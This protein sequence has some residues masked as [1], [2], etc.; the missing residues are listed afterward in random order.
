MKMSPEIPENNKLSYRSLNK[1]KY[2]LTDNYF[3]YLKRIRGFTINYEFFQIDINGTAVIKKNYAW[4]G[5]SGPTID[6][7]TFMRGSLIHDMLYQAIRLRFLPN[8]YRKEADETL[9]D[10][11][12]EDG[13]NSF[14]AFYVYNAVRMFGWM[15]I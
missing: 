2:Q 6:T 12:L 4:D 7:K 5:P 15:A 8:A 1:Y 14:R 9:R 10:I 3:C 13:M 11:C